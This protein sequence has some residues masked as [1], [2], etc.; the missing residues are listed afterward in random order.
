MPER[1]VPHWPL[2]PILLTVAACAPRGVENPGHISVAS[3][4]DAAAPPVT[5]PDGDCGSASVHESRRDGTI[6]CFY[7]WNHGLAICTRGS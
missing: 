2:I 6:D 3:A 4:A 1:T 5:A 7:N